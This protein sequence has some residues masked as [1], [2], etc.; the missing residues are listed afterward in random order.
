M[1]K[2]KKSKKTPQIPI[3]TYADYV[4]LCTHLRYT[5]TAYGDL[6][7]VLYHLRELGIKRIR[8]GG[9]NEYFFNALKQVVNLGIKVTLVI[10][11][12]DGYTPE[13]LVNTLLPH[14]HYIEAIEGSNELD[15]NPLAICPFPDGVKAFH[16]QCYKAWKTHP[17]TQHIPFYAPS[18]AMQ[19]RSEELG[20]LP[21]EYGNIHAY[22]DMGDPICDQTWKWKWMEQAAKISENNLIVCTETGFHNAIG[23]FP[24]D[25]RHRSVYETP[26]VL[27][28]L[29]KEYVKVGLQKVFIYELVDEKIDLRN[30][31]LNFG[32]LSYDFKEKPVYDKLKM[33]LRQ[34][35]TLK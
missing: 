29:I 4:G 1:L 21:C 32:L 20:E 19:F 17:L 24:G 33:L 9:K 7:N 3:K 18:L 31:E 27:E 11:P 5:D 25:G 16:E 26:R 34:P 28:L 15:A 30:P 13:N 22:P 6:P 2:S 8:D 10:D 23:N 14:L 35:I 12:R